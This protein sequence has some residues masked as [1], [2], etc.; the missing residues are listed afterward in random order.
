MNSPY[1]YISQE[2]DVLSDER[3]VAGGTKDCWHPMGTSWDRK[4]QKMLVCPG[5]SRP[6]AAPRLS[7]R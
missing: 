6:K 1:K 4:F 2:D 3:L 5:I 7:L